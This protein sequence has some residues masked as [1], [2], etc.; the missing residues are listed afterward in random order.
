MS[1][2]Q[3]RR[4][5]WEPWF[6]STW[7]VE[8]AL[9]GGH[10]NTDAID[11]SGG[12]DMSDH[13]VNLKILLNPM[14]ASGELSLDERNALL[15]MMTEEVAEAVLANNNT[16][17]L[18]LS[19]DKTR[20][21]ADPLAF[22]SAINWVCNRE[23]PAGHSCGCPQMWKS[24]HEKSN[25]QGLTRP[26]LAVLA[27]H[28]Q[29]HFQGATGIRSW[30]ESRSL[31]TMSTITFP[32]IQLRY[33]DRLGDHMLFRSIGMTMMLNEIVGYA[34]AWLFPTLKDITGASA[35]K[36]CKAWL[37]ALEIIDGKELLSELANISNPS[38]RYV[39]WTKKSL[40]LCFRC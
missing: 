16:H 35:I 22:V 36:I 39:A 14:V 40:N 8:F 24:R 13:E 2:E 34:G 6:H 5:R 23:A 3:N 7:P 32:K 37:L 21:E 27:A 33:L 9:S 10:I 20:S 12:V 29:I 25:G 11:N 31:T 28:V 30:R 1:C 19:L 15:E 18:Q 26:E 38:A 17:A 4:R